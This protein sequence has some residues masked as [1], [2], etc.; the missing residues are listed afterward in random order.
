[1]EKEKLYEWALQNKSQETNCFTK[2]DRTSSSY[3]EDYEK[4]NYLMEY[5]YQTVPELQ[6]ELKK[7]WEMEENLQKAETIVLV[8]A[9]K[10]MKLNGTETIAKPKV[11]EQL[12]PY[13]YNF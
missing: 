12:K 3:Y 11:T 2:I 8:A 1:M 4:R 5:Q 6:K 10:N 13:I 7:M 9:I